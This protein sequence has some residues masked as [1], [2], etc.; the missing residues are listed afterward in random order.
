MKKRYPVRFAM[1]LLLCSAISLAD[2]VPDH[3]AQPPVKFL[4]RVANKLF[5]ELDRNQNKLGNQKLVAKIVYT[6]VVP[7][8][9]LNSMSKSVVGRRYWSSATPA[10]RDTFKKEFTTMVV[11]TYSAAIENYNG[12]KVRFYPL[13]VD[14]AKYRLINVRSVVIRPSGQQ[15][16]VSYNLIRRGEKWRVYDFSVENISMVMSY[17]AQF[18]G[19][20]AKSGL[21][22]LIRRLKS[23]NAKTQA[24]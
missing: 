18:G 4:E 21:S 16:P 24:K 6:Y 23:H 12:D 22:G 3:A 5:S 14:P 17:R 7:Y 11:T 20:L 15:I 1:A 10:Q 19:V 13:R 2:A 9:D 8:F